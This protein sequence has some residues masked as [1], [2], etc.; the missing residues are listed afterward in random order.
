MNSVVILLAVVSSVAGTKT[1]LGRNGER[2]IG[3]SDFVTES[4]EIVDVG[5]L[6]GKSFTIRPSGG[7]NRF[8]MDDDP[9]ASSLGQCKY[10]DTLGSS[11]RVPM[12]FEN[13]ITEGVF[14][15]RATPTT[16]TPQYW[17]KFLHTVTALAGAKPQLINTEL[18]VADCSRWKEFPSF[19]FVVAGESIRITPE[20]YVYFTS[21]G[22]KRLLANCRIDVAQ[23]TGS[24]LT[25]GP[26]VTRKLWVHYQGGSPATTS[27]VERARECVS[28]W[29]CRA[30]TSAPGKVGIC[31]VIRDYLHPR[32]SAEE[33]VEI[34]KRAKKIADRERDEMLRPSATIRRSRR[35]RTR[36][37]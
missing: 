32:L 37:E 36:S 2:V 4:G 3:V 5:K 13:G 31:K 25:M 12:I 29:M 34:A 9:L 11:W 27:L 21:I 28:S 22:G 24:I 15:T 30:A 33:K 19:T 14:E 18:T 8:V 1:R 20:D 35:Q 26:A 23:A 10:V 17:V 16:V 6:S 7:I